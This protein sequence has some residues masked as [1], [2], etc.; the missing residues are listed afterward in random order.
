LGATDFHCLAMNSGKRRENAGTDCY[1]PTQSPAR[2]RR[3]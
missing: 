2:K 1:S 3:N